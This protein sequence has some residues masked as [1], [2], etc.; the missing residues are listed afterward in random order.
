MGGALFCVL[1]AKKM[2]RYKVTIQD[3]TVL[4]VDAETPED[5]IGMTLALDRHLSERDIYAELTTQP[6]CAPEITQTKGPTET[7]GPPEIV[8]SESNPE[9]TA[10]QAIRTTPEHLEEAHKATRADELRAIEALPAV[11]TPEE[12][13]HIDDAGLPIF[14]LRLRGTSGPTLNV[15]EELQYNL[16]ALSTRRSIV[17]DM[18]DKVY[19]ATDS[20]S[21]RAQIGAIIRR[22]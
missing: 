5:A 9:P 14:T 21:T 4:Y 11:A 2:N 12:R 10:T 19:M 15:H 8:D 20:A 3:E 16:I 13:A 6:A 7:E 17:L 22:I 18:L 1:K